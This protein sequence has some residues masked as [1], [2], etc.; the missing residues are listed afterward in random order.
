LNPLVFLLAAFV[1]LAA[2][3]A[4]VVR[5]VRAS[6]LG[7]RG[8]RV[9]IAWVALPGGLMALLFAFSLLQIAR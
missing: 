3:S 9:D 8:S 4:L 2:Q 7:E 1:L 5:E 6:R